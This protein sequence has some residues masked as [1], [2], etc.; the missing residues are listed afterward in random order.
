MSLW[1]RIIQFL[2]LGAISIVLCACAGARPNITIPKYPPKPLTL[3]HR[4]QVAIVLGAGGARGFAHAGAIKVLQ[5]AGVPI[6]LI[7]GSSVGSFYGALLAD[8]GNADIAAKRM[9]SARFWD[10]ADIANVP[11]LSGPVQGYRY[12][13]FLLRNMHVVWF[14][15]LK[16]PLVIV[17]T[18]LKTG[19]AYIISSGPVAPAAKASSSIPGIVRPSFLYGHTL[20]DGGISDPI[21]V[22]VAKKYH[23]RVII[24]VNISSQ[25]PRKMPWS[26]LG[27]Y[28]RASD[29][30]WLSFSRICEKGADIVIRPQVGDIGTFDVEKKEALYRE[31]E[32]AAY[33][34]LPAIKQL[35]ARKHIN[36]LPHPNHFDRSSDSGLL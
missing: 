2:F 19:H 24:A 5:D 33:K 32:N 31:G 28:S 36:L 15:Q 23:P 7:V 17:A 8:S 1:F 13:K 9:L 30:A 11:S 27:I 29:I 22:D 6:D 26:G 20:I 12:E 35:L 4:P 18:N 21:P 3:S 10:I 34:M 14:D 25:L 16:I